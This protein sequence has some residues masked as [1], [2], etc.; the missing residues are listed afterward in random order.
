METAL[1]R[2]ND[3]QKSR[4]FLSIV[5]VKRRLK[6]AVQAFKDRNCLFLAFPRS[7]A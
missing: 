6:A 4:I 3:A 1:S 5:S 7:Y 2:R